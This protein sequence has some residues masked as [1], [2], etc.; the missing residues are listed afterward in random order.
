MEAL[1]NAS[2]K[3]F[4]L[5]IK[6]Y[7]RLISPYIGQVCRFYPSCSDYAIEA[8]EKHGAAKGFMMTLS[9]LCR[10]HPFNE[11]GIDLVKNPRKKTCLPK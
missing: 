10:C 6:L 2:V 9:R 5:P 11:G 1:K 8:F 4:I 7:K 3:V